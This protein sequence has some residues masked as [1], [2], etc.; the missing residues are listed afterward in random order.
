[1]N[2]G[3]KMQYNG[4]EYKVLNEEQK[5]KIL[6]LAMQEMEQVKTEVD[7][8]YK[9]SERSLKNLEH[10]HPDLVKVI[11]EAI[12]N[13]PV[14]FTIT[15]GLRTT[16]E[17]QALYAKGRTVAGTRVTQKNGTTNKSNHQAKGDGLGYA[18]DLY[19]FY[20]GKVQ[21]DDD[22]KLKVIAEHIKAVAKDL[23]INIEWGGDW[24]TF[25]DYPHFELKK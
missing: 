8:K 2:W 10:I 19:S 17:Q 23:K 18:V 3:D 21:V 14:D 22:K 20:D 6:Y 12:K 25:K 9:L 13:S 7:V 24:K 16:A 5:G 1:M 15:D 4:K 11:K